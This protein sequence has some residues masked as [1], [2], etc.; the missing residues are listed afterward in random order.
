M[1]AKGSTD[2]DGTG[3]CR[4]GERMSTKR[5]VLI[6]EDH[7]ILRDGLRVLLENTGDFEIL[8]ETDNGRDALNFAVQYTPE[9]A[10]LDISM[11]IINGTEVIPQLRQRLPDIKI[12]VLTMHKTEEYVRATL[13]AGANA[14]VLKDDTQAE[15]LR[16][17]D[18][19][20]GGETYLSSGICTHVVSGFL[21]NGQ[22]G[23]TVE[24]DQQSPCSWQN[25][26]VR[27]REVLKLVAE[28][29]RNKDIAACLSLSVKTVEKHRHSLMKKLD[30]HNASELTAF[31]IRNGLI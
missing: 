30:V 9:L 4:Q 7:A 17:I 26:M 13:G 11:R 12:I 21:A 8:A 19:V 22:E 16:A 27:E 6:A 31:A 18:R 29:R 23:E 10:I 1:E 14:Y 2:D 5:T 3:H 20:F 24:Q 25:L 28:G 15:L